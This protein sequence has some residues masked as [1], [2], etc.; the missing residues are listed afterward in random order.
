[1]TTDQFRALAEL[2]YRIRRFLRDGDFVARRGRFLNPNSI[3]SSWSFVGY[4]KVTKL[5][6]GPWRTAWC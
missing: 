6:S 2:R 4:R 1:M 5:R 3:F